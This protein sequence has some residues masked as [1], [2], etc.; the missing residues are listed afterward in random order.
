MP[1]CPR[2]DEIFPEGPA[3]PRCS[4]R[5][6]DRE[7]GGTPEELQAVPELPMI[8]VSRRDRRALE[9]LSGPKAPSSRVLAAAVAA[10]IFAVG[11]LLGRL[12]SIEPAGPSVRALPA[13]EA[14][15][16]VDVA[17][18]AVYLLWTEEPLATIAVH[19]LSSGDVVPRARFSAPFDPSYDARTHVAS[20]GRSVALVVADGKRS[21][22]AFAPA[23][24]TPHG[25]V[26]GVEA[27]WTS[28]S[29]LLI[30]Q[31]DGNVYEWSVGTGLHERPWGRADHLFQAPEGAV[32]ERSDLLVSVGFET[33]DLHLARRDGERLIATDG[34][35][36]L[37]SGDRLTLWDGRAS[38]RVRVQGFKAVAA[39]FEP[40]GER[41]GVVLRRGN[42]L[43]VAVVDARGNAALKPIGA[44]SGECAPAISWDRSGSWIYIA[45]GDGAL[46]AVEASGG[47][48]EQVRTHGVGC[49]LAWIS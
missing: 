22:V 24:A 18:A 20:L 3:C 19:T 46:Y 9:R 2:C 29:E 42:E 41:A 27:A 45:P 38:T 10:L 13:A 23:G 8:K 39:G 28:S 26:P 48:V 17:G 15:A 32:V 43:T 31:A 16:P 44:R 36:A 5:L 30:L 49:G 21:F 33:S 12:G 6:I 35:R 4:T 1:W 25:W 37:V 34:K 11:F 7:R 40:S 14:L 47:Q